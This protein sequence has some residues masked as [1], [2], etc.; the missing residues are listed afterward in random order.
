[1]TRA[2]LFALV[3]LI[4]QQAWMQ[5]RRTASPVLVGSESHRACEQKTAFAAE[6]RADS[7]TWLRVPTDSGVV[8]VA[9]AMPKGTGPFP[10]I[11]ILH[12]T[13]GFAEEY[14]KLARRFAQ[15]GIVG[16]AACWF[17]GRRGEG[18][19]FITPIDCNDAPPLVDVPGADRF[20]MARQTIDALVR[21]VAALP[22]VQPSH[23]ALFGHS[24]GAGAALDYALTRLGN[25]QAVILNSGGYPPEVTKRAAD[26]PV[27]VLL[28]HGVADGPADGGSAFTSIAT[29]RQFEAALRAANKKVEAKF[30]DKGGHN[31]LFSDS[32]QFEDTVRRTCAFLRDN[33]GK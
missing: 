16:V 5:S 28:L 12:G 8:R 11:V 9:V 17:A 25:V 23:L 13:H 20:R 32:A 15:N 19:R 18:V 7:V 10:A 21:R 24:R 33:P 29:V 26:V 3:V 1:M 14:V 27:P 31:G 22:N 30:Y 2:T 6:F 4:V